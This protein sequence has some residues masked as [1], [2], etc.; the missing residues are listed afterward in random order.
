MQPTLLAG[1]L[2]GYVMYDLI[3][4]FLHHMDP[5][6]EYWKE[7]KIYHMQHHYKDGMMGYGVS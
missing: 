6:N 5:K 3:H 4:Y 7:L 2:C 1:C